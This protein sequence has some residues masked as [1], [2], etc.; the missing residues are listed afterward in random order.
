[1]ASESSG[2]S[3]SGTVVGVAAGVPYIAIPPDTGPRPD[4]PLVVGWHLLD[5]PRTESAFAAALPLHGLDAWRVYLGLPL[6]GARGLPFDEV[7][8]LGRED[9]VAN[10]Y[11]PIATG[12]LA[13]FPDALAAL[14]RDLGLGAAPFGLFGGSMGAAVAQLVLLEAQLDVHALVLVSP[15][16]RLAD[17]VASSAQMFGREYSWTDSAKAFADRLDFVARA[18]EFVAAG[19]PAVHIL[20]GAD[21]ADFRASAQ[22]LYH[23]LTQR[24][25]DPEACV[26]TRID[27]MGH[28]LAD[29]P[30]MEPA[31]QTAETKQVDTF[32]ATW[33]GE[34]LH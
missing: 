13:E 15:L 31:P 25:A 17:G 26:I 20:V 11:E 4:A 14:R 3:S 32:A 23:A 16:I 27:G 24:Y 29:E 18:D 28:A 21:D 33:F 34:K 10:L 9:V 2:Q 1:M 19:R 7:M 30:G 12:A 8:R 6:C 5:A 22:D